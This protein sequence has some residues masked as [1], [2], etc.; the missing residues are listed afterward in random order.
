MPVFPPTMQRQQ[1]PQLKKPLLLCLWRN[2]KHSMFMRMLLRK[3]CNKNMLPA[4][5]QQ[6]LQAQQQ[7]H[8]AW[9]LT[10][11]ICA[12]R[13][14]NNAWKLKGLFEF[15]NFNFNFCL[16]ANFQQHLIASGIR[17]AWRLHF[18]LNAHVG[19]RIS[20]AHV[21][22]SLNAQLI[23]I[24]INWRQHQT[25]WTKSQCHCPATQWSAALFRGARIS[26]LHIG[27]FHWERGRCSS[28]NV[29]IFWLF[30]A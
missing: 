27:V 16:L 5:K 25:C 19:H 29:C 11:K 13:P 8:K 28:W 1:P 10:R 18:G 17:R 14:V 23:R 7:Q 3:R 21:G 12:W 22:G 15:F 26:A 6:Q 30:S 2:S 9:K 4:K 24:A 20:I